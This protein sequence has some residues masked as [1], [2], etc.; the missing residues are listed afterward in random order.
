M[1][2]KVK[3]TG[4]TKLTNDEHL[5]FHIE[6]KLYIEKCDAE[7]ISAANELTLYQ[8]IIE[9]EKD[10]INR[11]AASVLTEKIEAKDAARDG[12]LSYFITGVNNAK[13]SPVQA[14][15]DAY[16]HL[17]LVL[18]P[19]QGIANDTYSR[20]SAQIVTLVKELKNESLAA[21]VATL[22]LTEALGLIETINDEFMVL[23]LER[24]SEVPSKR[25]TRELRGQ[26][27]E[28]YN[29]LIDK[30]NGTMLLMPNESAS[31]LVVDLNNL[32]DKT[33]TTYNQRTAPRS[34]APKV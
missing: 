19:Y 31:V 25:E 5:N 15:K 3:K 32:I 4:L 24:T 16:Q 30:T 26:V 14:H 28:I 17:S 21:M 18:A 12:Y 33:E 10:I 1:E 7:N 11:Q 29:T 9:K 27:D 13:N 8:A 2:K 6:V 20:E 23:D 22:G 34:A